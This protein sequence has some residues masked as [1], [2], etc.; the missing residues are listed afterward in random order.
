MTRK[1]FSRILGLKS[2][3]VAATK[4]SRACRVEPLED[5]KM[6]TL[7]V[8]AV[9]ADNRG[10]ML[11]TLNGDAD[12][13]TVHRTS[14]QVYT[15]GP[16]GKLYTA[17]DLF[18]VAAIKYSPSIRRITVNANLPANT[19]YRVK[20]VGSRVKAMDGT[21]FDG[22]FT[23]VY[24]S[25][26]GVPG[27]NFELAA[28]NDT[29]A[30][31]YFRMSTSAGVITLRLYR[32]KKPIT[33]ANFLSYADSGAYDNSLF[34]RNSPGFVV[35][36]GSLHINSSNTLVETTA[37]AAIPDEFSAHGV[38]HN[39]RG[40]IAMAKVGAPNTATDAFFFNLGDNSANLDAQAGG[41]TVFAA[42]ANTATLNVMDAISNKDI[43]A[44][45]NSLN[46]HGVAGP[47]SKTGI[48]DVPVND[49]NKYTGNGSNE[50]VSTNPLTIRFVPTGNFNATTDL[51]VIGRAALLMTTARLTGPV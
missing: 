7:G 41:F 22:D 28:L 42:A 11:I 47:F 35:Q 4:R 46:G 6:L 48:L 36:A 15:P 44:L 14:V 18:A 21:A 34:D 26:N 19:K 40:T 37:H 20:I 43:V 31:P 50:V 13:L 2:P 39:T 17:D 45:R 51:V 12:P 1:F 24:P 30:T 23:G 8:A 16:D 9:V 27:G 29:S 5:R 33:V 10:Q 3:A 32:A 38:I 49:I 25:G